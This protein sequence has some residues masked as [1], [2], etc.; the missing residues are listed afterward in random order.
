[1]GIFDSLKIAGPRVTL[2]PLAPA[3]LVGLGLFQVALALAWFEPWWAAIPLALF[4]LLMIA[5]PLF[6]SW[7]LLMP[8]IRRGRLPGSVA[9]TFDDGPDPATTERLLALL[10]RHDAKAT[11]F[12]VGQKVESHPEL[13]KLLLSAGHEVGNH[14]QDHDVLLALR[15]RNRVRRSIGDCQAALARLGVRPLVFRPPA[16]VVNPGLWR[17][18]LEQ[19]LTCVTASRRG[20]DLGNRRI[21][22]LADRVLARVRGGDIIALHDRAPAPGLSVDDW[23]AQIE[24]ILQGLRERG[25]DVVELSK[26]IRRPVMEPSSTVDTGAVRSV[27]V[28]YD[29]VADGYDAEQESG[30]QGGVRAAERR[31]VL[32]RLD[33]LCS[34]DERVLE[35]GAGTGRH[36]LELARRTRNVVALDLSAAMLE[37]LRDKAA[38]A[39]L[40]NIE[41]VTAD[42]REAEQAGAFDEFDLICAFSVFEYMPDMPAVLARLAGLLRPGGRLYFTTA[43]RCPLRLIGQVGN[44][45]R[46]GIWLHAR[47]RSELRA[48]LKNAGLEIE[49]IQTHGPGGVLI[50]V[51][52]RSRS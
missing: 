22:G 4:V 36:T 12:L 42:M 46:Q 14:T 7:R 9:L 39:G 24:K 6:P 32:A 20:M 35:I 30:G 31:A 33:E 18:L 16:W 49:R 37:R 41:T 2:C 43:H 17:V 19:G 1:M 10:E 26:L 34:G 48:A 25:L 8:V 29:S 11:F 52:A 13:V 3:H 5:A 28:F 27:R 15:T 23:L 51:Q 40:K 38:G 45:L 50:E 47:S 44:A 21:A